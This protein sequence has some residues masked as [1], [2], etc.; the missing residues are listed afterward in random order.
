M[1]NKVNCYSRNA[2]KIRNWIFRISI[3]SRLGI[4]ESGLWMVKENVFSC[5]T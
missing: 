1:D 2:G 3:V 4:Q 5:W